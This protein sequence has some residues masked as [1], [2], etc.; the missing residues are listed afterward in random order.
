VADERRGPAWLSSL[1]LDLDDILLCSF[2]RVMRVMRVWCLA[3]CL[4]AASLEY[5]EAEIQ[6][7]RRDQDRLRLDV[8]VEPRPLGYS[9]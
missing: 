9:L 4:V 3:S 2:L 1:D 6:C 7:L 5:L 8:V